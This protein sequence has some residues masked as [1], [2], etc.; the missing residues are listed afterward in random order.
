[1]KNHDFAKIIIFIL[2]NYSVHT[3]E[4]KQIV[5]NPMP[6]HQFPEIQSIDFPE[7]QNLNILSSSRNI[8]VSNMNKITQDLNIPLSNNKGYTGKEI[9]QLININ[10][11]LKRLVE[12]NPDKV[13]SMPA[14]LTNKQK[15]EYMQQDYIAP[16][17]IQA[18]MWSNKVALQDMLG[19]DEYQK[20]IAD[21][22]SAGIDSPKA[23]NDFI[24]TYME[25]HKDTH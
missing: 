19:K 3:Q 6:N 16:Q 11:Q 13:K 22:K 10:Q 25:I 4:I 12:D 7:I 21:M 2:L 14:D 23:Q 15:L 20:V 18:K 5:N 17:D 1:M 24:E 8:I 9:I